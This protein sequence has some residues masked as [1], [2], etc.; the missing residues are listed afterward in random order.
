MFTFCDPLT[1]ASSPSPEAPFVRSICPLGKRPPLRACHGPGRR[2]S[3][4]WDFFPVACYP[5]SYPSGQ[6]AGQSAT[7]T[8]TPRR[9]PAGPAPVRSGAPRGPR[10]AGR[11]LRRKDARR[12]AA[13]DRAPGRRQ[14][15]RYRC[16]HGVRTSTRRWGAPL[17]PDPGQWVVTPTRRRWHW[18]GAAAACRW[19]CHRRHPCRGS[20]RDFRRTRRRAI[21]RLRH[22]EAIERKGPRRPHAAPLDAHGA[23]HRP[24]RRRQREVV[25]LVRPTWRPSRRCP[26]DGRC[27][28]DRAG[29]SSVGKVRLLDH[30]R[31][32]HVVRRVALSYTTTDPRLT[33]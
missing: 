6:P 3:G 16:K 10:R 31:E 33:H 5:R 18:V 32:R 7:S 22:G 23:H 17:R 11:W 28:R 2:P 24:Q 4:G 20:R 9:V 1:G 19:R 13:R 12:S 8:S 27:R 14:T 15:A 21:A 26:A 30:G 25:N 29:G